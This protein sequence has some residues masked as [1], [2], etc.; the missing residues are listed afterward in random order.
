MPIQQ[1]ELS[2]NYRT[3][4][5]SLFSLP[6]YANQAGGIILEGR[7]MLGLPAGI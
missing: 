5:G 6:T 3:G 7:T 4:D 1:G 2:W